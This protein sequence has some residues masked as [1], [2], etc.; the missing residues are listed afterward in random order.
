MKRF[1]QHGFTLVEMLVALMIAAIF[2]S[3]L[4]G[5]VLATFETLR[6]G[7]ERTVAQENARVGLNYIANDIRHATDIAPLRIESYKDWA[8]GGFPVDKNTLD[9][10]FGGNTK[11][12]PIYRESVD[13][14]PAAHGYIDLDIDGGSLEPDEYDYFRSDGLPYDVRALAPN[15]ISLMFLGSS[16]VPNTEYWSGVGNSIDLDNFGILAAN[17]QSGIMRVTYEHQLTQPLHPDIYEQKFQGRS[18]QFDMVV[19]RQDA[20]AISDN[21]DFVI[22][23]SFEMLNPTVSGG[24]G[25][26][27]ESGHTSNSYGGDLGVVSNQFGLDAP[28]LRQPVADH[29]MNMRLRYWHIQGNEM[30]EIRYDP[31]VENIKG[32]NATGNG[33]T[34]NDGYYRYYDQYGHEIYVWYNDDSNEMV[35]LL[36]TLF[37]QAEWDAVPGGSFYI[38]GGDAGTDEFQRGLLL[39]EGWKYV[40]AVSIT[41]KTANNRT[42]D[43][44]RSTINQNITVQNGNPNYDSTN[45]DYGMGFID[46]GMGGKFT[47]FTDVG[48]NAYQPLYQGADNVRVSSLFYR[49][50]AHLFDVVEPNMNPNYN[51]SAFTTL[52]TFVVPPALVDKSDEAINR[53]RFGLGHK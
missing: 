27:G 46:F 49:N 11:A 4:T 36:K 14:A 26:L 37:T 31:D 29:V 2:F 23:R 51:P 40:N 41:V 17:P 6:S 43:I 35:P 3:I 38:D 32:I 30:V 39:F 7:D 25:I 48:N 34:T 15:R 52:Q 44:Y 5:V 24:P 18:K 20:N 1:E 13:G 12:W 22:T 50:S 45:P 28:A 42:L 9:P 53:L 8:T 10:Y 16:Y 47:N 19:N 21:L 33:I